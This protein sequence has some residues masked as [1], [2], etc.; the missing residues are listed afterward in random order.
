M[1]LSD[2]ENGTRY[3]KYPS[4]VKCPSGTICDG[5]LPKKVLLDII[6]KEVYKRSLLRRESECPGSARYAA[7]VPSGAITSAMPTIE[8]KG[9]GFQTCKGYES[10]MMER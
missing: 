10:S 7:K 3:I 5:W 8:P 2:P 4:I 1:N 9:F 6:S